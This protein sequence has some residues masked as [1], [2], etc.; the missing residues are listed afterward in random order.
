MQVVAACAA[1]T[2]RH[3]LRLM[4]LQRLGFS[5]VDNDNDMATASVPPA[6]KLRLPTALHTCM[7]IAHR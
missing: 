4:F 3:L 5:K 1:I 2:D 6:P 7:E